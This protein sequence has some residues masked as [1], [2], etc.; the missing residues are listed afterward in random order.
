LADDSVTIQRVIE[1]TFADEDV[2]VVA[3]SDGEQAIAQMEA[4]PPDIVLADSGM[5]GKNGYELAQYVKASPR[6]AH[7]PVVLLTGAF[8]PVDQARARAAGC[9]GV[10]SKP[11]EPQLVIGRVRELLARGSRPSAAAE[12]TAAAVPASTWP[13]A[14]LAAGVPKTTGE[15]DSYFD[16][17]N[18][19]LNL[20]SSAHR[21]GTEPSF[22]PPQ[23]P[24]LTA[25]ESARSHDDDWFGGTNPNESSASSDEW[26]VAPAAALSEPDMALSYGS[27]AADFNRSGEL[28]LPEPAADVAPGIDA[29]APGSLASARSESSTAPFASMAPEA[30]VPSGHRTGVAEERLAPDVN[31]ADASLVRTL[32][33][34]ADAFAAILASEDDPDAAQTAPL[35]PSAA[36]PAPALDDEALEAIA[37]RVLA[38]LSDRVVRDTV[39]D[40]VSAVAERLVREEIERIKASVK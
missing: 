11:F 34:L 29:T 6:L 4:S 28:T 27:P 21:P 40:M 35:W 16:E 18:V 25:A 3:V 36:P 1:L 39:A 15:I 2:E 22:A 37:Q 19:A 14:P 24:A 33:S 9:E 7:I 5:P 26:S 38:R 23:A 8:E 32:P 13:P 20:G 12:M 31:R 17:L 10:L 30:E